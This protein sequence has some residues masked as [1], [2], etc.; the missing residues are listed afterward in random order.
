MQ[1]TKNLDG[2]AM[3][4]ATSGS[5]LN[6]TPV[7][8]PYA[9]SRGPA[10]AAARQP[11]ARRLV[12]PKSK[13]GGSLGRR[14]LTLF[15][16][17]GA[18]LLASGAPSAFA[19]DHNPIG[20]TGAFEG[21]ITTGCA[22]NVLNHNATRQI[23][24][25][26]VPGAIGKY[27]LK[28]TR[29]FNSRR[30]FG[31]GPGW[32]HEYSWSSSNGKIEYPNGNVWDS[33]CTGDWGLGG[34]LAVSDWPTTWNGYPA[35]RLADGGTVVFENPNWAVA[36][37]IID[38]YGQVTTITIDSNSGLITRVTEPGGRYLQFTYTHQPPPNGALMLTRVEAHGLGNATDWVNYTY[39]SEPTGGT[40][41]PTAMCLTQVDYSDGQH[42]YYTY[43][44]DNTPENPSPPCPCPLKLLPLV[45]TC[46]DV[47]YK[48]P[49][50]HICY[51]YQGNGPHG[52]IIAERYSLNGSTNGPR[53]SRIDPPAPSPL[54]TDPNF[55]TTYT[56]YRGDGP[57]RAFN[58]T[59]LHL[60]RPPNE[61]I[62]PT[63]NPNQDPAPQQFL[64]NYTDF[65]GH[66]TYLG[67]D[68]NWYVNSVGDA[69]GHTTGYT[70]GPPPNAYPGPKGI[71]QITKI[72]HP[73]GTH[74]DYTYQ[75]E[76]SPAFSGHYLTSITD[77]RTKLTTYNR[78]GTTHQI[79]RTDYPD[80]GYE[81][82]T[83]N[84]TFGQLLTHRFR[85]NAYES[86]AYD[87]RG[88]LTEKW[89]PKQNAIPGGNNDPYT[90]YDYYTS[91]PWTDRVQKM[92][93]PA[94]GQSLHASETY[95]YDRALGAD[96]L[97]NLSGTVVAGRGLVTKIIHADN[98]FQSFRYDAYGNKREEYDE[99]GKR[100]QYTYDDYNRVLAVIN[101]LSQ[102]ETFSYLKPGASSSYLH[103]T[104][105]VYT[106]TSRAGIVTTNIYD[107]NFR[108]TSTTAAY[109]T[110]N[111]TTNFVYDYVGNLTRVTDPRSKLT[112]NGYDARNRKTSTTEASGTNL[113][114]TTVW[115]YDGAS[116]INQIDRPDGIHET[117]GYDALNR[118]TWHTVPRQVPGPSPSPTP[119][120]LTTHI[121]YNPSGTIQQV[122]DARG[123]VTTFA[124]DASDQKTI[125]TYYGGTQSQSWA[126]DDAHNL[127]TRTTVHNEI[128]SF[129]YDNRN[130]KITMTWNNSAEWRYFGYDAASHLIR[131]LN[132]TGTWNTNIIS[133]VIRTYDDA[134]RLTLDQQN[135]A[136][137]GIK[138]V[139][140][141]TY[142]ADGRL[143]QMN[144]TGA[145]YDYTY[146]YDAAGRFEKIKLTSNGSVVCQY[147]YDAS[148]NETHRYAYLP[149]SVTIDQTYA[150]DS[151]NRMASRLVKKNGTT[152][153]TEAYTYDHLNQITEVNRGNLADGFAYYWDGELE[154]ATYGGGP[155]MP[156]QEGQD[157]DLD[158][159]DNIDVNAGYQPPD[160]EA[161]EPAPPPDD[162]T[163]LPVGGLIPPDLPSGHSVGYYLDRAGNRQQVTDS[164]NATATYA[165][166]NINQY[167]SV[168]G[169]SISNGL[170]HE[171]S[172]FQA[173]NDT[174]LVNYYYV[175]DEHLKQVSDSNNNYYLYY[176]AL[177]RCVNRN[178]N[179][180][181]TYYIY[182]GEKPIL[183]YSS[184]GVVG[185]N[186]Y[187][188]GIDEILMRTD[189][190]VNSGYT[191]YYAQDH[192]GSV[193]HLLDGRSTPSSQT[194]N[195]IE[196]YAYD[197]FGAPTFLDGNGNLLNPNCTGY[198]NRF[199][200]T[201]REY[202]ATYR[203][204]Y[205]STF[206]FYEYR[207][208]AYNPI[209][210]RF[211]SEDPKGFAGG[212]YNL[213]RYCHNDPI[214]M[215]DPM[216][217]DDTAPTYNPQQTSLQK[218]EKDNSYNFIMGLMQRQFNSAISAGMA[219]YSAWSALSTLTTGQ[220]STPGQMARVDSSGSPPSMGRSLLERGKEA[221]DQSVSK[222]DETGVPHLVVAGTDRSGRQVYT[223]PAPGKLIGTFAGRDVYTERVTVPAGVSVDIIGH[224]HQPGASAF[225]NRL[226]GDI[227]TSARF[228]APVM[229]NLDAHRGYYDVYFRGWRFNFRP[230]LQMMGNPFPYP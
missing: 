2:D 72:T 71:G 36:T 170:E 142:D 91:G 98:K 25:I 124:Y 15:G 216:G 75:A 35:F 181:T 160:T 125:M 118:M 23:D 8:L 154:W 90:H 3:D 84:T 106:H 193:T 27:G 225:S 18:F 191:F 195:V 229:K 139:N 52:A 162:Y 28:M 213:F 217:L 74:I 1:A 201:G 10:S 56:E 81:T 40:I 101:P 7:H 168:S 146:S 200:F 215:T 66:T 9:G 122:T 177:G 165:P 22:Y 127:K 206:S 158:P 30:T 5:H 79:Y 17:I 138:N 175:N 123:K 87:T 163:D 120:N 155:H 186:V 144:V 228:N 62:C 70:R 132:G 220:G 64:Q 180:T 199:L 149:N 42:A 221:T 6:P 134:G 204:I 109:G 174:N 57:T 184:T 93:L 82:F 140:Y 4:W 95:E 115:H 32:S 53:V 171:V 161:P 182:D 203:K 219:G 147:A 97:T 230:D 169:C 83:Y 69:N 202:G 88:L 190:G 197:A 152:F 143:T 33:H 126:Y 111:L 47:R 12:T 189:P 34:P 96:G 224:S 167:T 222:M 92:T 59:S 76:P 65:Q 104:D 58:Y 19:D 198:N 145:S 11:V 80:T 153:S 94:N 164:A 151:L 178:L 185:R 119:I 141:P 129:T 89:N 113:A 85:N 38:P 166:N 194:G 107:E 121:A 205:V 77:E 176:D 86:F 20:V 46:R 214:D 13:G 159:T 105:S 114:T 21:V 227:D 135:V 226:G 108:K 157:P 61:D 16:F 50:R 99:L 102:T 29:Y 116:N 183:E 172:S 78:D 136:G 73:G 156:F 51:E 196:K 210:G 31:M 179:G 187:G 55:A 212:D 133:D 41:V 223:E 209:L 173:P 43:Q 24:D 208:R 192:E 188:K 14:R 48:G 110:L 131:A 68:A 128:Q 100:T 37:K 26:V 137:L 49:M 45:Q 54:I 63:W 117:K 218:A 39:T 44:E 103:T 112:V 67:Y 150:P 60:Q 211:M 207:A 148:S 130:R